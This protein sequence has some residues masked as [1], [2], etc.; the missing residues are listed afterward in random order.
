MGF[1][2]AI[3][4]V[5]VILSF[6][7][8]FLRIKP[9]QKRLIEFIA[10]GL[11]IFLSSI[12]CTP[13][14]DYLTY[15]FC[16]EEIRG[17]FWDSYL[18]ANTHK[19]ELGYYL[20]NYIVKNLWDNYQ[21]FVF[22]EAAMTNLIL[23]HVSKSLFKGDDE[24]ASR[25]D[26]TVTIFFIEWSLGLYNIIIVRQTIAV[27]LCLY[28]IK[29]I[30]NKSWVKFLLVVAIATLIHRTSCIWIL[31]YGLYNIKT[32][33]MIVR[34]K[35]FFFLL[36][37]IGILIYTIREIGPSLPGVFGSKIRIYLDRGSEYI[38]L[39]YSNLFL[40]FK[41][42]INVLLLLFVFR[43]MLPH[44]KSEKTYVGL[45]NLYLSG[46]AIM[47]ATLC[48]NNVFTRLAT[49]Y[50]TVSIFLLPYAF[51]YV[52]RREKI[53]VFVIFSLYLF[54]RLFV[55]IHSMNYLIVGYETI[56]GVL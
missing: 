16:F 8:V 26:F 11:S 19:M 39:R 5:F 46:A 27:M 40:I 15:R 44:F 34:L 41:S 43:F 10:L 25:K 56:F 17:T 20:L 54:L 55:Y 21:F 13:A 33:R 3:F 6:A 24:A 30:R 4:C 29:Y 12:R 14:G 18:H 1:Y 23:Y 2:V 53:I 42:S 37:G 35:Y 28:S 47:I 45:Y 9:P 7:E 32:N 22:V 48:I 38:G 31:S 51:R 49:S 36:I 50:N 52:N